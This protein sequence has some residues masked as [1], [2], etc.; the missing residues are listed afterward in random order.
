MKRFALIIAS[1]VG[2]ALLIWL[3]LS[4]F[5]ADSSNALPAAS[6]SSSTQMSASQ[7]ASP[8][9]GALSRG[10]RRSERYNRFSNE[11]SA[12]VQP[13]GTSGR[14]LPIPREYMVLMTRSMFVRGHIAEAGHVGGHNASLT[15]SNPT[16]APSLL[17]EENGLV[18]NGVT[19]TSRSID[20]LVEDTSTG[21]VM[22]VHTGDAIARG[23]VGKITLDSLE[24]VRDGHVTT[25]QIGQNF[26]GAEGDVSLSPATSMPAGSGASPEDILE[27]LRQKRLQELGGGK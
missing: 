15:S 21:R 7:A 3:G 2:C 4:A 12:P 5:G 9:S 11:R 6:Q 14:P 16:T 17:R 25:V 19:Q 8:E 27:R 13:S 26:S 1:T 22:T 10:E 18:F 20:A 23:T 24:Y